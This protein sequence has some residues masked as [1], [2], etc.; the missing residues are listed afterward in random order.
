[1]GSAFIKTEIVFQHFVPRRLL[2]TWDFFC[3]LSWF[4][5]S[6]DT[7]LPS[8]QF[9]KIVKTAGCQCITLE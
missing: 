9:I 2:V 6:R 5:Y 7:N 3:S 1:M 4:A 8:S